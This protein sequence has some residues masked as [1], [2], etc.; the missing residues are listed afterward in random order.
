MALWLFAATPTRLPAA[1]RAHDQPRAGVGLARARRTLDEQIAGVERRD[2]RFLLGEVE[3][4][5]RRPALA[6]PATRGGLAREDVTNSESPAPPASIS[7]GDAAD[8][9][10]CARLSSGL[11]AAIADGQRLARAV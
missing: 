9:S 11:P 7:I 2:E 4:L 6:M 8:A 10:R 3:R 1:I 5:Q